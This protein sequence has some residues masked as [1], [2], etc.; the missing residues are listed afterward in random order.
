[1]S[2]YSPVQG[3]KQYLGYTSLNQRWTML[4]TTGERSSLLDRSE[5]YAAWTLPYIFTQKDSKSEERQG[6]LDSVGAQAV[7]HLSNKLIKTLFNW[8]TPF[9]RLSLSD[10]VKKDIETAA[11]DKAAD[12]LSAAS[13]QLSRMERFGIKQLVK[14]AYRVAAILAGKQL[15]IL[16]NSLLYHPPYKGGKAQAY[17]LRDF[18][19]CRDIDG[20]VIEIMTRDHKEYNSFSPAIQA[21]MHKN[22]KVK[23][24]GD[25]VTLYTQIRLD[26]E[27]GKYHV[28]QSVEDIDLP[29]EDI[30]PAKYLPWISLTWNLARGENYGR[31]LVE[32]YAGSFHAISM[33][34]Q[35]SVEIAAVMA[36][37]KWL[38]SPSSMIDIIELNQGRSGNYL[39]GKE[40][41]VTP[42]QVNKLSDAQFIQSMVERLERQIGNGFLLASAGTRD[43]ERVT[44]LEIQRDANELEESLGGVY[45]RQ[46]EEWQVPLVYLIMDRDGVDIG[47]GK[48]IDPEVTTGLDSLSRNGEL[49]AYQQLMADLG[50][51]NEVPEE[52]RVYVAPDRLIKFLGAMHSVETEQFLATEAEVQQ[53]QAQEAQQAQALE[54]QKQQ[55]DVTTEAAKQSMKEQ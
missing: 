53:K 26:P 13:V 15:I 28:T 55:G 39:T 52:M 38:V 20:V 12:L 43:A 25:M 37:I 41:D 11:P 35:S 8:S 33:L 27:D 24:H 9:F 49:N 17:N 46:A 34:S 47:D 48:A 18:C 36:D 3:P 5:D 31:G 10:Q 7:N 54:A 45:S 19:I 4:N 30:Y 50:L 32:D 6:P 21:A 14:M 22:G 16:G 51:M 44:A 1:M 23:M 42:V 40:G 29:G 2:E